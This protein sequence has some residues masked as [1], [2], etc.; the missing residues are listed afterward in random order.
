MSWRFCWRKA[1]FVAS[2]SATSF[3]L[4]TASTIK[5][6]SATQENDK[7]IIKIINNQSTMP[8]W[9]GWHATLAE[10]QQQQ[11]QQQGPMYQQGEQ[12]QTKKSPNI[13]SF[14]F[15]SVDDL[16]SQVFSTGDGNTPSI[17]IPNRKDFEETVEKLYPGLAAQLNTM[18]ESYARFWDFL[19]M[20]EFRQMV[21]MA[22]KETMDTKCHPEV[23][24]DAT[25]R[26]GSG[27]LCDEEVFFIEARKKKQK[28]AFARFIGV[29]VHDIELEDI[30]VIGIAASGGGF[31]AML[32][33]SGYMKAMQDTG[34]LDLVM[35]AASVSGSCWS[36]AQY[37]SPL[38]NARFDSLL[39]HIKSHTHT[40]LANA[41]NLIAILKASPHNS[42]LLMQGIIERY[43]QRDGDLSL[44]DVWG[45]LLGGTL[46]TKKI[47]VNKN[48]IPNGQKEVESGI[49]A[50]EDRV[51]VKPMLVDPNMTKL[52]KQTQYFQDGSLP[53]PIYCVVRVD[54]EDDGHDTDLYEWYEFTPFE[55]GTEEIDAWVPVWA[56]GRKFDQ[57]KNIER[58]PEQ[59][60]GIMM[61]VFGSAFAASLAHF[62]KEIRSFMPPRALE[63]ADEII[64]QFKDSM[65]GFYPISPADFPNPFY[66][67]AI[68]HHDKET[69]ILVNSP[70]LALADAGLDNNIP[71]YPLL[72]Q[73]RDTDIIFAIDMSADIQTSTHFDR[74]EGYVQRR[75]IDGWPKGAGWP[76]EKGHDKKTLGTCTVFE[77]KT[78]HEEK[79]E[80][81]YHQDTKKRPVSVIY[82]PLI[83]NPN[84]DST[85][86]PQT[87][88][89]CSTW[90]FVYS[91][92]QS[93][94]LIGLAEMNWND[95]VEQV[96]H[97]LRQVWHWK[98]AVRLRKEN[99]ENV[100]RIA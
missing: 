69:N 51:K 94:K 7:R 43:H 99:N 33:I 37:Y 16:I 52:S 98:R 83:S 86:D 76:K 93:T 17:K 65:S 26:Y 71:F 30:P 54:E 63:K 88:Q 72:R 20:D 5:V 97:V 15:T 3:V 80:D 57:G 62:Y 18:R 32:G 59:T 14:S 96:R 42:K 28:E 91:S 46:L 84:Y 92:A 89:F 79:H 68:D 27:T 73:G 21:E 38:T 34:V 100:L 85:F 29:P 75:G 55:M 74:A 53:M 24:L 64:V 44:V 61:G 78:S 35:Y 58:L 25:V 82:F 56:F 8:I 47:L 81:H 70:K 95:N 66:R 23:A 41:N 1:A 49:V 9:F 87:A 4:L 45:L 6:D 67:L 50:E 19:T 36:L 39:D 12:Q 31:R 11:Q 60:L 90:N 40:H 2:C 77:S 22:E 10:E 13:T 48:N